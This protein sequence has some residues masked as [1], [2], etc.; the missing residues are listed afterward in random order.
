MG[1]WSASRA[2]SSGG[3]GGNSAKIATSG[4]A[5]LRGTEKQISYA[6]DIRNKYIENFQK[7]LDKIPDSFDKVTDAEITRNSAAG[8]INRKLAEPI[9]ESLDFGQKLANRTF[10]QDLSKRV[11]ELEDNFDG[12]RGLKSKYFKGDISATRQAVSADYKQL[13]KE[14]K[15]QAVNNMNEFLRN[16]NSG[17]A[18]FWI[19]NYKKILY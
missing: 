17:D 2:S 10:D 8:L 12:Y 5:E 14:R 4:L 18:K 15:K 11:R 9:Y 3:G 19:D 7:Q 1:S 13:V 16:S 6:N